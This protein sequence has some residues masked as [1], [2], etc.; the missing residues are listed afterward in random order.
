MLKSYLEKTYGYNEPIFLNQLSIDGLSE[1]AVR[2]A[3]KRLVSSGFL[4]RFDTGIYYIPRTDGILGKS[5]LDPAVVISRRYIAGGG[6]T[7]GYLTGLSFAVELGLT[8]QMSAV[9]EIVSNYESSNGRMITIGN[10]R[11]RIRKPAVRV[12]SDNVSLLQ[13]LDAVGQAEKYTELTLCETM[14]ILSSYIRK[15]GFTRQQLSAVSSVLTEAV[16]KK[17]IQWELIY[18]FV[19]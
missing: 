15:C 11:I 19:G 12:S 4:V 14:E 13:F 9:T 1:N 5:Y 16:A 2:Q 7:Y 18:E 6:N 17:L 10:Q 8:T 3:V